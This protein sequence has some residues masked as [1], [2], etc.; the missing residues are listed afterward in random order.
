MKSSLIV[1]LLAVSLVPAVAGDDDAPFYYFPRPIPADEGT[2]PACSPLLPPLILEPGLTERER[3]VVLVSPFGTWTVNRN[4]VSD[5]EKTESGSTLVRIHEHFR[6]LGDCIA[7]SPELADGYTDDQLA[8]LSAGK[9]E[10][11]MPEG[12]LLLVLGPPTRPPGSVSQLDVSGNVEWLTTH[13]WDS[14]AKKESVS[15]LFSI[16]SAT[17]L[18]VAAFSSDLATIRDAVRVSAVS[19]LAASV[20]TV[21]EDSRIPTIV[22]AETSN[23]SVRRIAFSRTPYVEAHTEQ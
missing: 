6:K 23:G 14:S 22:V 4:D 20:A 15:G 12:A 19:E 11:G 5:R 2:V 17:A 7:A 10:A 9:L 16:L 18:G 21:V 13:T 8:L 1:L 3:L